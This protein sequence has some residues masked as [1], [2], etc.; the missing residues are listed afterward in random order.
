MNKQKYLA[1]LSGL[2]SSYG[3]D[4]RSKVMDW[5]AAR[6]DKAGAEGEAALLEELGTPM[7]FIISLNRLGIDEVIKPVEAKEETAS[8]AEETAETEESVEAPK[9]EETAEVEESDEAEE[10]PETE[11]TVENEETAEAPEAVPESEET[12]KMTTTELVAAVLAE[13]EEEEEKPEAEEES[14]VTDEIEELE[15]PAEEEKKAESLPTEAFPEL[16]AALGMEP[17]KE[18]KKKFSILGAI[19]FF[20]LMIVPGIPLLALSIVLL[21]VLAVPPVAIGYAGAVGVVA[22]LK[23]LAYIPDAMFVFGITLLIIGA[24]ILVLLFC[25]WIMGLILKGWFKGVPNLWKR[26]V[27]KEKA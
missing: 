6:F 15:L 4:E 7:R 21:P 26:M 24:A 11:E 27:R 10:A 20:I 8:E 2:L 3:E 16:A 1:E 22:A 17:E 19:G 9:V 5:C 12:E 13:P 14:S 25:T 23:T 18:E